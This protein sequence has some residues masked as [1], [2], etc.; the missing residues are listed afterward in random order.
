MTLLVSKPVQRLEY[1][2]E[3]CEGKSVL[4]LGCTD[5][6]YTDAAIAAGTLMHAKLAEV[7]SELYGFDFETEAIAKLEKAGYSNIFRADLERLDQVD[8]N[9]TFEVILAGEMIEHLNNTGMFLNGI[10][11][12]LSEN[13][14]LVVT[15][16]NAYCAMRN[17]KYAIRSA[18]GSEEPVHPDHVA[19]FSYSTLKL[20]LERHGFTV[21]KFLF[22]DIGKEHRAFLPRY[23]RIVNDL[24]IRLAPQ[25]SDGLIAVCS[26]SKAGEIE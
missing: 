7:S 14:I 20:L 6:P 4:H 18:G 8:L 10:R 9:R 23:L 5:H 2:R 22:Y 1:I 26:I 15:T 16:V 21:D 17:F 11:R 24:S 12:F 19:Y 3:I 25:L 13:S